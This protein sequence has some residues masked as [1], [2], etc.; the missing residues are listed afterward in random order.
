M[1]TGTRMTDVTDGTSNTILI[2]QTTTDPVPWTKPADLN[3]ANDQPL[4]T[5]L[6]GKGFNAA[7]ADGSVRYIDRAR[8]NE[9][10]LRWYLDPRDGNPVPFD[11]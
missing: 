8:I 9:Q 1:K 7:F 10:T 2:V 4:P 5:G 11:F 6:Q 3:I